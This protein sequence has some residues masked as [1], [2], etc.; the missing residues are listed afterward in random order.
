MTVEIDVS[1]MTL[2]EVE[3]TTDDF[4][5]LK[6]FFSAPVLGAVVLSAEN[7][8]A[9]ATGDADLNGGNSMAAFPSSTTTLEDIEEIKF[10]SEDGGE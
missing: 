10:P 4:L 8:E 5:T 1:E 7:S 6:F 2:E 9:E 3:R